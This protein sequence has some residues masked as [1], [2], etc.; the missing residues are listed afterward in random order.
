MVHLASLFLIAL[1]GCGDDGTPDP[2]LDAGPTD[3]DTGPRPPDSGPLECE[4]DTECDDGVFCNGPETCASSTCA[5][6]APVS[7]D[8]DIA[9]TTDTCSEEMRSCTH[10]APD[11]DGDGRRDASCAGPTGP[12]GDDCDDAD[13]NRYPGNAEVCDP[14]HDEDC[15]LRSAGYRDLDSDDYSDARCC[16]VDLGGGSTCGDD[17]NDMAAGVHPGEA[18]SCD[19]RD[20]DCDATVDEDGVL[21]YRDCDGDG[22]GDSAVSMMGCPRPVT[23]A[24]CPAAIASSTWTAT[25]GDCDDTRLSAYPGAPELCNG[26][27]DDCVLPDDMCACMDGAVR[28]CGYDAACRIVTGVCSGGAPMCPPGLRT[29]SELEVCDGIDNN[30]DGGI[31]EGCPCAPVR[32]SRSC[33]DG[34]RRGDC[35]SGVETCTATGWEGCPAPMLERCGGGDESCNGAVDEGVNV[36]PRDMPLDMLSGCGRIHQSNECA[37]SIANECASGTPPTGECVAR[38]GFGHVEFASGLITAICI[39]SPRMGLIPQATLAAHHGG[40]TT[41]DD[42][43]PQCKAAIHRYCQSRGHAGGFGFPEAGVGGSTFSV[44]CLSTSQAQAFA[45]PWADLARYAA[46]CAGSPPHPVYCPYAVHHW[47]LANGFATGFGTVENDAAG[48][49]FLCIRDF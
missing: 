27:D 39:N 2:G 14:E 28:Q 48:A 16:N 19:G 25:P 43:Y 17:C 13:P 9:C 11:A 21:L 7:C 8:D 3:P 24:E 34:V 15:D 46:G 4:D 49:Q 26:L 32:G 38:G 10:V 40:C 41:L 36:W 30:C 42:A 44:F 33:N 18:D 22:F 20:N 6:G 1:V 5:A 47:C 29:G 35:M 12:L 31:D 23:M 37:R 45:R